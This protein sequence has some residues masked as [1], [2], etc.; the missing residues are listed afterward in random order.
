MAATAERVEELAG[1]WRRF[2][3]EDFK[4]VKD[5]VG[6]IEEKVKGQVELALFESL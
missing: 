4:G 1:D 5:R 3:G 6:E 2:Y